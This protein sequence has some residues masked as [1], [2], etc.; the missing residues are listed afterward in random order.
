[1]NL[2]APFRGALRLALVSSLFGALY[3]ASVPPTADAF[4]STA[5]PANNFGTVV[6]VNVGAGNTGLVR[7][8]VASAVPAGTTSTNVYVDSCPCR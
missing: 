8:D 6:N 4:T 2:H 3:A 1:M 5:L 7:F